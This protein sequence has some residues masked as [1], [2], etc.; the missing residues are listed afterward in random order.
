MLC[1]EESVWVIEAIIIII[2]TNDVCFHFTIITIICWQS[3]L[4]MEKREKI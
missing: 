1:S 3:E 2:I 4:L